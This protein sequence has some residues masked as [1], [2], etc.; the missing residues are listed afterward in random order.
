MAYK[1]AARLLRAVKAS[2]LP[3][4][5]VSGWKSRGRRAMGH[6][7]TITA[8]HTATP[9][10]FKRSSD[11]PTMNVVKNGRP[12]LPGPLAQLGLG[13][14]GRVYLIAAGVANHA[15]RSRA[16]SMTNPHAIG[17]EAEGAME[18]WPRQQYDAYV[19][20]VRAL[21]DEFD[22][23]VS[24]ALRHAETC[25][26]PGRKP[27]ASFS[28][29]AFRRAVANLSLKKSPTPAPEPKEKGLFDM[30]VIATGRNTS[31][32][33]IKS[34][35]AKRVP[36]GKYFSASTLKTGQTVRATFK[37]GI[38]G[39]HEN[40]CLDVSAKIVDYVPKGNPQDKIVGNFYPVDLPGKTGG[41]W[42]DHVYVTQPYRVSQKPRKGG[43]L[44]LQLEV[45]NKSKNPITIHVTE[46]VVEGD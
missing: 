19:R 38:T 29:P 24:R 7:A 1:N 44:R 14:S 37:L 12:G 10:S 32:R 36:T 3:Y 4:T 20:L 39:A 33:V 18:P 17:I 5:E 16:T 31:K 43:S 40:D 41:A 2:G 15:G 35:E 9:R 8:H 13:R 30:A 25:S 26:P 46:F 42:G 23:P 6:I 34:G 27:D 22:L 21:L 45:Q 28:G 11:Y